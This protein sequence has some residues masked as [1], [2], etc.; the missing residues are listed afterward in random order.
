MDQQYPILITQPFSN[1][2]DAIGFCFK[3]L[4][5]QAFRIISQHILG[6]MLTGHKREGRQDTAAGLAFLTASKASPLRG[7]CHHGTQKD[8]LVGIMGAQQPV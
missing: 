3:K 6:H 4:R 2:L 7:F 8:I 1:P 5:F